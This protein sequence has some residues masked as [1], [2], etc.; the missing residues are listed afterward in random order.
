MPMPLDEVLYPVNLRLSGRPC[1]VVGGGPVAASKVVGLLEAAA[2]VTVVAPQVASEITRRSGVKVLRRAYK[3]SDLA[4]MRLVI[5]ATN[6]PAVNAQ[7]YQDAEDAGIWANS[8]DDPQNCAFILPSKVRRGHLMVTCSTSGH[9]PALAQWM[10]RRFQ[11]EIGPEYEDL[12][13]L[14][15]ECREQFRAAG[16]STE[17]LAWQ[18]ALDSGMLEMVRTGQT[19]RARS[20]I[21]K[22]VDER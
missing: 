10:R 12:L 9:S 5:T 17:N 13:H 20:L 6:N 14:L 16:V 2:Q 4:G 11:A 21:N 1:L 3:S 19:D 22:L 8:A 18:K 7:V 15:S